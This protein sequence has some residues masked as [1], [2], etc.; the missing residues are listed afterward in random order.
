MKLVVH[1]LWT[2]SVPNLRRWAPED[3][4][5]YADVVCVDIGTGPVAKGAD[6]F[7]VT[8]ATPGGLLARK[9]DSHVLAEGPI[10]I[11][12]E[13]SFDALWNWVVDKVDE[14]RAD[15]WEGSVTRLRRWFRWE[16]D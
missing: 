3:P 8:A 12:R 14:S 5:I 11:L 7:T 4:S 15:T 6:V 9:D 10:L 2:S 13:Y 16:Y 1:S